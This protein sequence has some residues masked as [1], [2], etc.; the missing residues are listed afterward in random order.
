MLIY[1]INNYTITSTCIN[2]YLLLK[3]PRLV[4]IILIIQKVESFNIIR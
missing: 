1:I 4:I 2:S 3:Q